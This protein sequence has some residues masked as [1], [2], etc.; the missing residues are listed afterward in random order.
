MSSNTRKRNII[1]VVIM[2]GILIVLFSKIYNISFADWNNGIERYTAENMALYGQIGDTMNVGWYSSGRVKLTNGDKTNKNNLYCIQHSTGMNTNYNYKTV[3]EINIVGTKATHKFGQNEETATSF[4]K[5]NA[6]LAYVLGCSGYDYGYGEGGV[7]Y[8]TPNDRQ[9]A[10]WG[11]WTDWINSSN[12]SYYQAWIDSANDNFKDYEKIIQQA[13]NYADNLEVADVCSNTGNVNTQI[14]DAKENVQKIGPFNV[15]FSGYISSIELIDEY[16]NVVDNNNGIYYKQNDRDI[17]IGNI[18]SGEDFYIDNWSGKNIEKMTVKVKSSTPVMGVKI[19]LLQTDGAGQRLLTAAPFT[20]TDENEVTETIYISA[21]NNTLRVVKSGGEDSNRQTQVGFI[22]YK[23]GQGYLVRNNIEGYIGQ[24]VQI[25]K[26]TYDETYFS[27]TEDKNKATIFETVNTDDGWKGYFQ[28]QK[29]PTG[30]YHIGEVFNKNPGYESSSITE[31]KIEKYKGDDRISTTNIFE[32]QRNPN[33]KNDI[34]DYTSNEL[35]VVKVDLENDGYTKVLRVY[36]SIEDDSFDINIVKVRKGGTELLSGAK[37]KIKVFNKN[38]AY[39]GWLKRN[40][41]GYTYTA[42]YDEA[43]EWETNSTEKISIQNLNKDYHYEIYETKAATG[44]T[45]SKQTQSAGMTVVVNGNLYDNQYI[46]YQNNWDLGNS[47]TGSVVFCGNYSY[48]QYKRD[49][50]VKV[51]NVK[52]NDPP[53]EED[54]VYV[55]IEG[56]I[57]IDKPLTKDNEYDN[58]YNDGDNVDVLLTNTNVVIR[59]INRNNNNIVAKIEGIQNGK[60]TF[61]GTDTKITSS[62]LSNYYIELYYEPIGNGYRVVQFNNKDNGSKA[63]YQDSGIT[64]TIPVDTSNH[65]H[66]NI[67]LREIVTSEMSVNKWVDNVTVKMKVDGNDYQY[68]YVYGQNNAHVGGG[69]NVSIGNKSYYRTIYASDIAYW[70][71][72]VDKECLEVYITYKIRVSKDF[73][74]DTDVSDNSGK[75]ENDMTVDIEDIYNS[76]NYKLAD[77]KWSPAGDGKASRKVTLG[78]NNEEEVVDITFKLTPEALDDILKTGSFTEGNQVNVSGT[79]KYE[80][81]DLAGKEDIYDTIKHDYGTFIFYESIKVGERDIYKW[82]VHE[83]SYNE[84]AVAPGMTFSI[85]DYDTPEVLEREISGTVF[86][87]KDLGGSEEILGNGIYDT[88]ENKVHDVIVD[89]LKPDDLKTTGNTNENPVV[90]ATRY[91]YDETDGKVYVKK[92]SYKTKTN[93]TYTFKGII[94]GDYYIRFTYGDGSQYIY[95]I[96]GNK[97]SNNGINSYD[98]KSTIITNNNLKERIKDDIKVENYDE[99]NEYYW[100]RTSGNYSSAVDILSQ[101]EKLNGHI[102]TNGDGT[103]DKGDIP[104]NRSISAYTPNFRISIENDEEK[105][106]SNEYFEKEDSKNY[107]KISNINFGIIETPKIELGFEKK[108]TNI[109]VINS[110]GNIIIDGNPGVVGQDLKYLSDLD[111]SSYLTEGSDY[112]KIEINDEEIYGAKLEITYAI[113]IIN[114]SNINYYED[115]TSK[116]YGYY[117][118][119]GEKTNEVTIT[120]QEVQDYLDTKLALKDNDH[121]KISNKDTYQKENNVLNIEEWTELYTGI[122]PRSDTNEKTRDVATILVTRTLSNTDSDMNFENNAQVTSMKVTGKSL[123][124]ENVNVYNEKREGIPYSNY[125]KYNKDGKNFINYSKNSL[126]IVPPTGADMISIVIYSIATIISSIIIIIGIIVI[127]KKVL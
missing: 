126:T 32:L 87:D 30:T 9:K 108:M 19:N 37:F 79:C 77:S 94:P 25:G 40:S 95:D 6:K 20:N 45:L 114:N 72:S 78:R 62:T 14:I 16:G 90:P 70:Q 29:I 57:W 96:N 31:C 54:P 33:I 106:R 92:N 28:I 74:W 86:V 21:P 66:M 22:I 107:S 44:Y 23:E 125:F 52:D 64:G 122:I 26:M 7:G 111:T 1:L 12:I 98:Y 84:G 2:I 119:F 120:I 80:S 68:K 83:E 93:G 13:E 49:I 41:S 82:R 18:V 46:G 61:L 73:E 127:K 39:E 17:E 60:Y 42:T 3:A 51:S 69:T 112:A 105:E 35:Q 117:Y 59:L 103:I 75:I 27:W 99:D 11:V 58:L 116:K 71:G 63:I 47:K 91:E 81:Y 101:R 5:D 121:H 88:N 123:L 4:S 38:N 65:L 50:T 118:M 34:Y 85:Y 89:L 15:T 55:D 97:I 102:D 24:E 56:T 104:S 124:V 8:S 113:T 36:D 53:G 48:A 115:P 67:G 10:L 109:R 100:Y 76:K 110:Q 43:S